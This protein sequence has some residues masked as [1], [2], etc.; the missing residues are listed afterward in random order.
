[1]AIDKDLL[2]IA[3]HRK[4]YKKIIGS[5]GEGIVDPQTFSILK[6]FGKYFDK[7]PSKDVI[8]ASSFVPRFR[9]WHP[10]LNDESFLVYS[11]IIRNIREDVAS[12]V[13]DG[14]LGD[15]A[16]LSLGTNLA[17]VIQQYHEGDLNSAL[18]DVLSMKLDEYKRTRGS[19]GLA[20]DNSDIDELLKQDANEE[21]L[22][23]RL[24]C[25]N[26]CMR[27]LR[28]GDFGIIAGRPDKG[29]TTLMTSEITYMAKQLPD[30][31]NVLWICNEGMSSTILKRAY[32]SAL[33]CGIIKLVRLSQKGLLKDRYAAA[34]GRLDKIRIVQAHGFNTGH[35]EALM[36][37]NKPG[38]V[39]YDMIDGIKGFSGEAR[40]DRQLEEMY[41]WGR[42]MSV[43]YN[44]VGLAT[45]QISNEG[46]NE[47]WP[48]L[49]MLKDS[50][51]GKQGAC[52][53][54]IMIG[55]MNDAMYDNVRFIS[56]PK[57]KLRREGAKGNPRAEVA[58]LPEIA[59][60]AEIQEA[61]EEQTEQA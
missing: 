47:R 2:R 35:V 12:D 24:Q 38:I 5:I 39:V 56:L 1:M 57:N 46:D 29:K 20:W 61:T 52:D 54:Q 60:Y 53:F 41:K 58:Y 43:K 30:D 11:K 16:E 51:T 6:D 28:A 4:Q 8:E 15:I 10:E 22:K 21:G 14:I 45:S 59:R 27:P 3:K 31:Q 42:E 33:G 26:D 7:F 48:S 37:E 9:Q 44:C 49:G 55:A 13:R 18:G 40:T 23:W 19:R 36:E 32:Q 17:N 50:K 34:I 25:L